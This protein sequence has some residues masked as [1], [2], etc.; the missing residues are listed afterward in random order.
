MSIHG[1]TARIVGTSGSDTLEWRAAQKS[2]VVNGVSYSLAGIK[3]VKIDGAGGSD[4]LTLLGGSTAETLVLRPDIAD[5]M[6]AGF[7]LS[8]TDVEHT[9]FVGGSSDRVWLYDS[10]GNDTFTAT[11]T[12]A[13][14]S[15]AGYSNIVE[16]CG[17]VLAVAQ[18]GGS[19]TARLYDSAGADTLEGSPT[20]VRLKG[21]G[22][23]N[24]ARGFDSVN[25]F[26]NA[27]GQDTA[28]LRDSRGADQLDADPTYAWLRGAG[29]S[30]RA[31]GFESL[32]AFASLGTGDIARIAGSGGDDAFTAFS[33]SRSLSGGGVQIRTEGFK[34][35]SFDGRG[36]SDSLEFL[37]AN[38]N[39]QLTGRDYTGVAADAI[40]AT[41][42]TN[43]EEVLASVR[44]SH[45]LATD[46]AAADFVYRQIGRK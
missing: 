5:A 20:A 6:S 28:T 36:G 39:S 7:R 22:Y 33:G 38:R 21:Q 4:S 2:I 1:T 45:R 46:L 17:T 18:A 23:S 12:S 35:V 9:R 11:P 44:A 10:A 37:T 13:T 27:G 26:A 8:A 31:E 40:F 25:V 3:N 24:E 16:G 30:I 15:G 41:E 43:V 19:D 29:F 42:F 32:V 14:L 34:S